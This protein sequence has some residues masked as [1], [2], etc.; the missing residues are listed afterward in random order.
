[1]SPLQKQR[2]RKR[3]VFFRKWHR[4]VGFTASL[5]LFNLALTGIL[6]NHYEAFSLHKNYIKT[7]FL[8]DWYGVKQPDSIR[9]VNTESTRICQ[10]GNFLFRN[11][12]NNEL[13][14]MSRESGKLISL[15][16]T[17]AENYLITA[18]KLEIYNDQYQSIETIHVNEELSGSITMAAANSA[19][20][21]LE[22]TEQQY[23]FDLTSF[24]FESLDEELSFATNDKTALADELKD[25]QLKAD[26][27]LAY[28]QQQI[29]YLKFTQDLHSGQIFATQ[30]KLFTDLI[31]IIIMLLAI[32]GFITWQK[33]KNS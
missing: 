23:Q 29:S 15:V 24:E 8:L 6:L 31:G 32:S 30:G 17:G 25:S 1:M 28:R 27:G 13:V 12:E 10:A 33:R 26:V 7:A 4:R 2:R 21:L 19:G 9:C 22:T 16:K 5:F 18:D 20:I 3:N 11:T 14:L